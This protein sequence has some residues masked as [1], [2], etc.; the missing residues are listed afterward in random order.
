M[1]EACNRKWEKRVGRH[2]E[3]KKRQVNGGLESEDN[4]SGPQY[5]EWETLFLAKFWVSQPYKMVQTA[6]QM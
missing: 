4:R 1:T 5:T 6:E 3:S 2:R